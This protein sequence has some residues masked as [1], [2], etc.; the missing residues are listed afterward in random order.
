MF[1]LSWGLRPVP[2]WRQS[3]LGFGDRFQKTPKRLALDCGFTR[4]RFPVSLCFAFKGVAG[5]CGAVNHPGSCCVFQ[6]SLKCVTIG[7]WLACPI[8]ALNFSNDGGFEKSPEYLTQPSPIALHCSEEKYAKRFPVVW[9][10]NRNP[11]QMSGFPLNSSP[12]RKSHQFLHRRGRR[13]ASPD[14]G[15]PLASCPRL[16]LPTELT[17]KRAP[18]I[19]SSDPFPLHRGG[20]PSPGSAHPGAERLELRVDGELQR[21]GKAQLRRERHGRQDNLLLWHV[22]PGAKRASRDLSEPTPT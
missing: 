17:Y 16:L 4:V 14:M 15:D 12:S 11:E 13:E 21:R 8:L 20:S 7:F 2:E 9:S 10:Q 18:L 6:I 19:D 5:W 3:G 22:A 1:L